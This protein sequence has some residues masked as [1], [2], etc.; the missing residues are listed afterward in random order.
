MNVGIRNRIVL[1][2][3]LAIV[4]ASSWALFHPGFFR[5]HDY[6][7]GARIVEMV[8]MVAD[9]QVPPRWSEN[10]GYG[11]G[12]PLFEFYAPLPYYFGALGYW[13][14]LDLVVSVKSLFLIANVGTAVGAYLLGSRLFGRPGGLVT[15]AAITLAPYRAVNLFVRGAVGEAW[16]I[17]FI[18]FILLSLLHL[19]DTDKKSESLWLSW[20]SKVLPL[21]LS[22]AGLVLSHN[23]TALMFLPISLLFGVLLVVFFTVDGRAK[24]QSLAQMFVSYAL[25]AGLTAFYSIPAL[26]EKSATNIDSIL[27]GYFHYS[28]HFLYIRQF[29]LHDWGYG[30]SAWGPDD[31]ISFFIG[32][33]QLLGVAVTTLLLLRFAQHSYQKKQRATGV[34]AMV[35]RYF[36][37]GEQTLTKQRGIVLISGLLAVLALFLSLLKSKFI[38]DV[39]PLLPIIQFPWR[40]MSVAIVFLGIFIGG[41]VGLQQSRVRRY[42]YAWFLVAVLL[43]HGWY[44][45]PQEFTHEPEVWYYSNQDTLRTE[46][47]GILPDFIPKQLDVQLDPVLVADPLVRGLES[48]N[49]LEVLVDLSHQKLLKTTFGDERQ[50]EWNIAFFP[51]W[52]A[53]VDGE[54]LPLDISESG[55]ITTKVPAGEHTVGIF[56]GATDVRAISDTTSAFSL[57]VVAAIV[58]FDKRT[59][60]SL[61]KA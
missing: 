2:F 56:M 44:F 55:L 61:S 24:L 6:V 17:L 8:R 14:G 10:F 59:L 23:L 32:A 60:S 12:M 26:V 42:V 22:V 25:A 5:T 19:V 51:G 52:Q 38:W 48:D 39:I 21:T 58:A 46:M 53:E 36:G 43:L 3:L 41:G 20:R 54:A 15:S 1:F 45:H 40:W 37:I 28:H 47:S 30:G 31:D 50:L 11:Y 33:G 29:F 34:L 9:G 27:S 13:L 18:P 7:H 49:E 4:V 16:G 35:M 57:L